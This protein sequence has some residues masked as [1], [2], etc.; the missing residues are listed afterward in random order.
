MP[1]VGVVTRDGV[2]LVD[3]SG[4]AF[5]PAP[6]LPPGVVRLQVARPGPSDPTT[7]AAL[8][9]LADLPQPLRGRWA[10]A[11]RPRRA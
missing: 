3:A 1:V 10:P 2:T 11:T 5:A 6:A 8:A 9:V 7:R 4:V